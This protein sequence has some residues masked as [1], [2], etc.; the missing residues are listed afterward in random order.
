MNSIMSVDLRLQLDQSRASR[1]RAWA[2]LQDIRSILKTSAVV[3]IPPA[4]IPPR[5]EQE[6]RTLAQGLEQTLRKIEQAIQELSA[7]VDEARPYLMGERRD[8]F[9]QVHLRLNRAMSKAQELL[10]L[11]AKRF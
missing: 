2:A 8:G 6:G 3:E 5:F 9:P 4:R 7:A 10:P 11:T 1:R